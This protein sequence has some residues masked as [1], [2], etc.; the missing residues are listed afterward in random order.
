E[1]QDQQTIRYWIALSGRA[2]TVS[3]KLRHLLP[4]GVAATVITDI[5]EDE[6]ADMRMREK[7]LQLANSKLI[8]DGYFATEGGISVQLLERMAAVLN[9]WITKER[10]GHEQDVLCQNA[11]FSLKLVAKRL[12]NRSSSSVLSDTMSKCIDIASEYQTVDECL[13][14]NILLLAGELIRSLNMKSTMASAVPLLKTCLKILRPQS[15]DVPSKRARMRLQSLSGRRPGG[16]PLLIS[17]L[18]CIQR[19]M[20]QFAPYSDAQED[21]TSTPAAPM[22]KSQYMQSTKTSIRQKSFG[23]IR[24]ALLKMEVR[25]IPEY[26][27]KAVTDL[28]H[29]E[30]FEPARNVERSV[31]KSLLAMAEVLT[32]NTLRSVVNGLIDWAEQGLKPSATQWYATPRPSSS[33]FY[34]SFNTLALPYFGRLMEL[35]GR[36]LNACNATVLNE[37]GRSKS[38]KRMLLIVHVIDFIGNCARHRE[39]FTQDR[40]EVVIEP[41]I[42]EIVN[43]KLSGH[44]MRCVPHISDALYRIADTHPDVFQDILDKLLLKTRNNKAKIRYRALLVM[45]AILEKVG[46]GVAPHL[47]MILPFLSELLEDENRNVEE[48]CDRVVRLLQSKFGENICEGFI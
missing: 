10:K 7:A 1:S 24:S 17:V 15:E 13:I 43:S 45:E 30:N 14:G 23:F 21:G 37:R 3:E 44:E 28:S 40:A 20:D 31:F 42:N 5:L 6:N 29:E 33:R 9:K 32:E 12:C 18:T 47:P 34:D 19:I 16:S 25:V 35:S 39:F 38:R 48:Q 41:L 46:D 8:Y 2:E 4:G 36:I 26:F 27:A 22:E 11:A